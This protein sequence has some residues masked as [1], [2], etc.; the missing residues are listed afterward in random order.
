MLLLAGIMIGIFIGV[1]SLSFFQGVHKEDLN[2]REKLEEYRQ[3]EHHIQHSKGSYI[4]VK[5]GGIHRIK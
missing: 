3:K 2:I 4:W 1:V 5:A